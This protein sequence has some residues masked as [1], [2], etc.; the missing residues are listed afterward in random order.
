MLFLLALLTLVEARNV[1][2][3]HYD[4]QRTG[5]N[6]Q[7][8]ILNPTN[9]KASTFGLLWKT[10]LDAPVCGQVLVVENVNINNTGVMYEVLYAWTSTNSD[11]SLTSAFAVDAMSG[12]VLWKVPLN[13]SSKFTTETGVI[14]EATGIWYFVTRDN[15]LLPGYTNYEFPHWLHALDIKTGKDQ[16]GSPLRMIGQVPSTNPAPSGSNV[17]GYNTTTGM[18]DFTR[19][20]SNVRPGL[21]LVNNLL[22]IAFAYNT[23]QSPYHGWIFTYSYSQSSGFTQKSIWC[24]S[25]ASRESGIWQAGKGLASDGQY[26]Y[27]TTG[28]GNFNTSRDE[29]GMSV[30]RMTMDLKVDDYFTPHDWQS[31]SNGDHD[32]GNCGPVLLWAPD[33]KTW[34]GRSFVGP[35]KYGRSFIINNADMGGFNSTVDS[36]EQSFT[37]GTT[38]QV[39][40]NGVA[41]SDGQWT[42][43]YTFQ[44]NQQLNQF[45]FE[46]GRAV[47]QECRDRSRMPSSA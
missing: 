39:G 41:W 32:M 16:P 23:D 43:I 3:Q 27:L 19:C 13:I 10:K 21:L 44:P 28:N 24:S 20:N 9:V 37:T 8:T 15:V 35:S 46:I 31:Q 34:S 12:E 5:A 26:I 29:Y 47:Q 4:M 42:Y 45:V 36:A 6:Q 1:I 18:I 11:G 22:V 2:T 25:A 33:G 7:E 14:D 38:S 30:L 17:D 40:A